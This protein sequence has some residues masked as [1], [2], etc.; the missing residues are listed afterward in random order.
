MIR[1]WLRV[2]EEELIQLS[3]FRGFSIKIFKNTERGGLN[4]ATNFKHKKRFSPT[5]TGT[6]VRREKPRISALATSN[7]STGWCDW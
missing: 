4:C 6:W 1:H 3:I 5:T 2:G 7:G